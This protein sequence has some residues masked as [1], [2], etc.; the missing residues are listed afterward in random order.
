MKSSCGVTY[1]GW[2]GSVSWMKV[3]RRVVLVFVCPWILTKFQKLRSAVQTPNHATQK[4]I[5]LKFHKW[6][7]KWK[8][9][10]FCGQ[11][12]VYSQPLECKNACCCVFPPDQDGAEPSANSVSAFN[13]LRLSHYT[14]RQE[15]LERSERLL[16]AFADRLT[17]VPI[18]LPEMV[19]ALMA[20][21]YTLKQVFA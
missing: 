9:K 7:Q 20:Q 1:W 5:Y 10:R 13:L 14:G 3:Q 8:V 12:W 16:A 18:A 6:R 17:R 11:T 19:R 4:I 21:H 2:H 15:W